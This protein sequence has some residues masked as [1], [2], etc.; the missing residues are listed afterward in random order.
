MHFRICFH[1]KAYKRNPTLNP[2]PQAERDL[3]LSPPF[4]VYGERGREI[5]VAAR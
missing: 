5:G 4:S 3:S 1:E 2:S